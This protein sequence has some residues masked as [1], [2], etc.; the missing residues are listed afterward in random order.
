MK[1]QHYDVIVVGLGAM[2]SAAM[3][4]AS[5]RGATV[6]GIDRYE[7]PHTLGSSHGDTR[8][9]RS[10]IGEGA[11][12][13]PFVRR[14]DEIW[15]EL[16]ASSGQHALSSQRRPHHCA[17]QLQRDISWRRRLRLGLGSRGRAARHRARS[18]RART[19]SGA[20]IRC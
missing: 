13:L 9:T 10:A 8:I 17:A 1:A 15:R 5:K 4:Q 6:L 2:G 11:F 12:Y 7:P 19:Q 18:H 3:Y 14:S 20:A 16:E